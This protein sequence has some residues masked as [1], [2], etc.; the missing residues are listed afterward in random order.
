MKK[1][2][3]KVL[4]KSSLIQLSNTNFIQRS[5]RNVMLFWRVCG[6]YAPSKQQ[7]YTDII[8]IT[9]NSSFFFKYWFI[10]MYSF[11]YKNFRKNTRKNFLTNVI[12][13]KKKSIKIWKISKNFLAIFTK[14]CLCLTDKCWQ[15]MPDCPCENSLHPVFDATFSK[16]NLIL[17]HWMLSLLN[18]LSFGLDGCSLI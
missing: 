8:V 18:H 6:I 2:V 1:T 4:P 16:E 9:T 11:I 10:Q 7:N 5:S 12:F 14:T 15:Q 13:K 3:E 17:N